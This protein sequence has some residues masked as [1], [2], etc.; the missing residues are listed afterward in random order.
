MR[1]WVKFNPNPRGLS[2]GDC[3]VRSICAVTR[4]D[5]RTVHHFLCALSGWLCNM[6]S[7]NDVWWRALE[8]IGFRRVVLLDRCPACYTVRDFCRDHPRGVY[9]LGPPEHAVAVIRG[10]YWDAWDSGETIPSFYFTR[11]A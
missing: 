5:W 6:P 7:A 11:E 3:T 9:I 1:R 8:L 2:V 4:L 10:R